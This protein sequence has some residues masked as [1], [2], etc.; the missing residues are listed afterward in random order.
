MNFGKTI[1]VLFALDDAHRDGRERVS[2]W[3]LS[4]C[5][6]RDTDLLFELL[7][8]AFHLHVDR[9]TSANFHFHCLIAQIVEC[10]LG[11]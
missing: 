1:S 8:I 9:G 5:T 3:S 7:S 10:Q 11:S 2:A 4:G 6:G